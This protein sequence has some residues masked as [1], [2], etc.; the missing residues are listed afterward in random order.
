[1][2]DR[3]REGTHT[4]TRKGATTDKQTNKIVFLLSGDGEWHIDGPVVVDKYT[5]TRQR[6]LR[7][8]I[9]KSDYG[10]HYTEA[11]VVYKKGGRQ[12]PQ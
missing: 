2:R 10:R 9:V 3:E 7:A 1:M 8:K 12:A 4:I 5:Q 6:W 11:L